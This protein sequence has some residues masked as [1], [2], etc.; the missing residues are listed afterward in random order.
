MRPG[1][2]A[3]PPGAPGDGRSRARALRAPPFGAGRSPDRRRKPTALR[4]P[5]KSIV[6]WDP[7][8]RSFTRRGYPDA[9]VLVPPVEIARLTAPKAVVGVHVLL[10][11]GEPDLRLRSD[12]PVLFGPVDR[13]LDSG[14]LL[15][16]EERMVLERIAG[17]VALER[18]RPL[19][20]PVA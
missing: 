17:L 18:H 2:R 4:R 16:L 6:S 11:L 12:V 14:L 5:P 20:G 1:G 13:L 3:C 9:W 15:G 19:Q 8:L 7:P 10:G